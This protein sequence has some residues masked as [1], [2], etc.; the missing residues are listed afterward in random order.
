MGVKGR[1]RRQ[2]REMPAPIWPFPPA[3]AAAARKYRTN[4]VSPLATGGCPPY[5][6]GGRTRLS[7]RYLLSFVVHI[8][9]GDSATRAAIHRLLAWQD[10]SVESYAGGEAFLAE[11]PTGGG[12]ILLDLHLPGRGGTS[13]L[14]E[15]VQSGIALPVILLGKGDDLAEAVRA[16]KLGAIDFLEKPVR[17][18][19][20]VAAVVRAEA[21]YRAGESRRSARLAAQARL[22]R[23]SPRE[24]QM[25][26][27]LV[28]GLS[29][30]AIARALGLSP[31]TVE[32]HRAN[33]MAELGVATLPDALRLAIDG[34]LVAGEE[35]VPP[36][37]TGVAAASAQLL[38][39]VLDAS[40]DGAWD[41]NLRTGE[42]AM[43]ERFLARLGYGLGTANRNFQAGLEL[44]HPD[45]RARVERAID[46]HLE[47]RTETFCCEYRLRTASGGWCWNH[48]SGLVVERDPRTGEPLR[49]VGT[50]RD[51]TDQKR[52]EEEARS[53]AELLALAQH[54]AATWEIDL[55]ALR[56]KL[57]PRMR[58]LYG[59]PADAVEVPRDELRAML[60]PEDLDGLRREVE[61]AVA[62]GEPFRAEFRTYTPD[63][64]CRWLLGEGKIVRDSAGAATRMVGLNQDI[65]G[66]KAA[67]VEL[68]RVQAELALV[69]RLGG[70][71]GGPAPKPVRRPTRLDLLVRESCALAL[72]DSDSKGICDT[73]DVA[74][75]LTEVEIDPD[76]IQQILLNL[77]RNAVDALAEVPVPRRR[78]TVGARRS[79]PGE[80]ELWVEDSGPGIAP[81]ARDRLFRPFVTTKQQGTGIGL[82]ICR[83]A[84][85]AHGGR[86]RAEDSPGG[87]AT[88]RFTLEA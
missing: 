30:K 72:V 32:M 58:E 16:M 27:G 56:L 57:T 36:P 1:R 48:D 64:R 61:R 55:G 77:L 39:R 73:I 70:A 20:L 26:E 42:I 35:T 67:A 76:Q 34:G 60:H 62:T 15:I 78:L 9:D 66:Q 54:D 4:T 88:F 53:A 83:A 65:T 38:R 81:A 6:R 50:A 18:A 43:S 75:D 28:A 85:E 87:G 71:G 10:R 44:V 69:S 25:L 40:G 49:M 14:E 59:L 63:G 3:F 46:A 21:L 86:I 82:V 19:D 51:I 24:R 17:E 74:P 5:L 79:A 84:V 8:V 29:N 68:N 12:C 7:E 31:R 52:R 47:G 2:T 45:D 80:I 37:E 11:A 13:L 41:W 33:M 22:E 23:L